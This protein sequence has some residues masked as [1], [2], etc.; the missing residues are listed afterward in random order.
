MQPRPLYIYDYMQTT[1]VFVGT[2]PVNPT[3]KP[4]QQQQPLVGEMRHDGKMINF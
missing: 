3:F 4:D 2:T 1:P